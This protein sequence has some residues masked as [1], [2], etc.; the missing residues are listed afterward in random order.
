M[1]SSLVANALKEHQKIFDDIKTALPGEILSVAEVCAAALKKGNK[2]L[3][4][5][6][7][8]S[9]ADSQ[10]LAAEFVGRFQTERAGLAA[11]ALTTDTS[12]LTAVG[13]D[14][15]YD[16]VFSR[17]IEALGQKG[18]VLFALSTS[19]ESANVLK[20]VEAAK[21]KGLA[22][23]GLTGRDGGSIAK[24]C[25]ICINIPHQKSAR[26]QEMHIMIGHIICELLDDVKNG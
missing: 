14:Y 22:A 3:F 24:T 6:N 10:H 15:G 13:N 23:V 11:I 2:L 1:D 21:T 18:D 8:G 25:D 7:G 20:A 19:G 9:A 16:K 12:V 26:I 4:C 17:Q 5:G